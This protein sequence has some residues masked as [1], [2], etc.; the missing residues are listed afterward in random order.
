MI[1]S[2]LYT[3]VA[4]VVH[5]HTLYSHLYNVRVREKACQER[6]LLVALGAL[7]ARAPD[8]REYRPFESLDSGLVCTILDMPCLCVIPRGAGVYRGAVETS[9]VSVRV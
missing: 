6:R 8:S 9:M 7:V 3:T 4:F 1:N 2:V 5:E